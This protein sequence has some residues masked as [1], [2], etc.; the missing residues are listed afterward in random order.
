[1]T[2]EG[3][4]L[5]VPNNLREEAKVDFPGASVT[6]A[7]AFLLLGVFNANVFVLLAI[8][9]IATACANISSV[10]THHWPFL[11]TKCTL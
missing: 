2:E 11:C 10:E 5:F 1:M 6:L 9:Q 4:C 3:D 8:L 7:T